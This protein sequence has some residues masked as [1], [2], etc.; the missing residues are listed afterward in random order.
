MKRT[1]DKQELLHYIYTQTHSERQVFSVRRK[2]KQNQQNHVYFSFNQNNNNN[3]NYIIEWKRMG[4]DI[5]VLKA[6]KR[7]SK[8]AIKKSKKNEK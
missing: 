2:P 3:N 4:V 7:Y 5:L 1:S 8:Q 6:I